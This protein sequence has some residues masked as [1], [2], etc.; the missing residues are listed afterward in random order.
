MLHY[1]YGGPLGAG[2][3]GN[4]IDPGFITRGAGSQEEVLAGITNGC[5]TLYLFG[6][7]GGEVNEG[8][9]V[10]YPV[11]NMPEI[12]KDQPIP[13]LPSKNGF[14]E[15][16]KQRLLGAKAQGG[17]CCSKCVINIVSCG[18][19][20]NPQGK[21]VRK[22]IAK[23]TGCTVCGSTSKVCGSDRIGI[24]TSFDPNTAW[25]FDCEDP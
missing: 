16:L 13:I 22:E 21:R 19:I 1:N 25:Q 18:D 17:N 7:R 2:G 23:D 11:P 10:T 6:H 20:L 4:V 12:P 15:R 24:I 8:G 9:I 3:L 5:C 14:E